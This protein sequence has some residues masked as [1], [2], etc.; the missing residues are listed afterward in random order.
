MGEFKAAVNL[1]E[2]LRYMGYQGTADA[3]TMAEMERAAMQIEKTAQPRYIARQFS[4][5]TT[6]QGIQV[7]ETNLILTGNAIQK[8]LKDCK[9]GILLCATLG[10]AVETLLRSMQ[11]RDMGFAAML[12]A[13][14][15]SAIESV[16]NAWEQDLT[17]EMQPQFLTDRFSPG[18][19]DLPITL[20][21]QLCAVLDTARKIGVC[22]SG[23]GILIPR[24]TVTAIV[25]IADVPQ[26]HRDTKCDSCNKQKDCPFRREGKHCG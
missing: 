25:G 24:K 13:C 17:Q 20:Q 15:S 9:E 11:L 26:P 19:G 3:A 12:D 21:K 4:L 7:G 16:C 10:S 23:S 5:Q 14:A 18:Y 6:P 1:T 8:L 22:V 2:A